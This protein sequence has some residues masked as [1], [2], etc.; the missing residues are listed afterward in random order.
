[1][2]ALYADDMTIMVTS[3]KP[4]LL[5]SYMAGYLSDL[6]RWLRDRRIAINVSKR[7]AIIFA[8]AEGVSSSPDQ[9]SC[10][11][12][13]FSVSTQSVIWGRPAAHLVASYRLG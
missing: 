10:S 5:V 13:Q 2:L 4:V 12:S 11:G 9:C 7:T 8:R 1:M 6:E 3:C